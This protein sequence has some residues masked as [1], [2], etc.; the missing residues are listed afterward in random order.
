MG[1]ALKSVLGYEGVLWQFFIFVFSF[2]FLPPPFPLTPPSKLS[3]P[4]CRFQVVTSKLSLPRCRF[5]VVAS[6]LSLPR[7][8]FHVVASTLSLPRC[9]F[10]VVASKLSLPRCRFHVVAF[11]VFTFSR[12]ASCYAFKGK[13]TQQYPTQPSIGIY[14]DNPIS[15]FNLDANF[16]AS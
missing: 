9:R 14:N 3:L 4:S 10:H 12:L 6:K 2:L 11:Q 13:K 15:H 8:R 5:H 7:C 1:L 16:F